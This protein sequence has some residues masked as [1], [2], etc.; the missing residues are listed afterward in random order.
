MAA[1][2]RD[3]LLH[4]QFQE[5]LQ[6]ELIRSPEVSAASA[7]RELCLVAKDEEKRLLEVNKHQLY[8]KPSTSGGREPATGRSQGVSDA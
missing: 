7:Y 5:G 2:T 1:G 3:T 8:R 6:Y 4:G